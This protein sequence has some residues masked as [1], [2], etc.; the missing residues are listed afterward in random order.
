[1]RAKDW[2]WTKVSGYGHDKR[3][4]ISLNCLRVTGILDK[5]GNTIKE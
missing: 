3:K 5:G 2:I 4:M 1:M